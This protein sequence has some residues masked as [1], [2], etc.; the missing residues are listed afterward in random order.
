MRRGTVWMGSLVLAACPGCNAA[1]DAAT[2]AATDSDSATLAASSE[3]GSSEAPATA[4]STPTSSG[5]DSS[6]GAGSSTGGASSTGELGE[7]DP[8]STGDSSSTGGEPV[9]LGPAPCDG[10]SCGAM[11]WDCACP[12]LAAEAGFIDLEPVAFVVGKGA[13]AQARSSTPA[14]IFYSFRPAADLQAERPLFVFFNGGPGSSTGV[15]MALGTGPQRLTPEVEDNPGSWA[16]MG[17]L[18]YID[19]RGTGF[20]YLQ[21]GDAS[22]DAARSAAFELANFNTY[23]D[24]ADFVR[25]VLRFLTAHPQLYTNEVVIVG[26]SYG[27]VRATVIL[28]LL[29]FFGEYDEGGAAIYKDPALV[30]EIEDF[31]ALRDPE[32]VTW[33]P[34]EIA[35]QFGRQVLIQPTLGDTQRDV[36]GV[37]LDLPGSPV[38][39]LAAQV[40]QTFTPCSEKGPGCV[41][42]TNAIQFIEGVGRSRYDLNAPI[43]WLANLFA[44]VKAGLSDMAKLEAVLAVP[45]MTIAGLPAEQRTGAFRMSGVF[46]Y[47]GDNGDISGLG[48]LAAWDRYYLAL[49]NEANSLFRSPLA[50]FIGVASGDPHYE[51]LFLHNLAYV[52][53]FITSAERDVAI[54]SPSI[55]GSLAKHDT[56]VSAI[57]VEAGEIVVQ[58]TEAPFPGE[59]APGL[60]RIRFPSYDASHAVS[61][62]QPQALRDDVAAWLAMP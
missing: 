17:H 31:L 34:A 6:S 52:D 36:A 30:A 58:F 25:V 15:L 48:A 57:D 59:P 26:E 47:P 40:G 38:F 19:A 13:K 10:C 12:P 1:P 37:L 62:D 9:C 4:T 2:G 21:T 35:A 11:G 32:V 28:N 22:D 55:P 60:R 49:F 43:A 24:A 51:P 5:A 33:G 42:Y 8:G 27:G 16:T 45:P 44:A 61:I 39:K 29:L 53:T 23:I 50:Q 18:L 20:S 46:S 54:Y 3:V 41:P 56:I 7:T 14:R